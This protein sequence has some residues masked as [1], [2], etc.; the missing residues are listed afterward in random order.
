[1]HGFLHLLGFDHINEADAERMESLEISIL[2][3]LDI[4][5]PYA[6]R[7]LTAQS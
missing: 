5:D 3:S 1:V 4:P 2:A 7:P 6:D